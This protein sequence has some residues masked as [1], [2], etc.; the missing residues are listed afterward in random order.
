MSLLIT[1]D[2]IIT[3]GDQS[4]KLRDEK[5]NNVHLIIEDTCTGVRVEYEGGNDDLVFI[6]LNPRKKQHDIDLTGEIVDKI[7]YINRY[8]V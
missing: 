1:N 5:V 7:F 4:Y 2:N 3:Y 8:F 6:I